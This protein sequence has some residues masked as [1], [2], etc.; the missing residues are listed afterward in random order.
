MIYLKLYD[1][2]QIVWLTLNTIYLKLVYMIYLKLYEYL[3]LYDWPQIV[4]FTHS[5]I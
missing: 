3:K 1:L 4:W 5:T 2:P